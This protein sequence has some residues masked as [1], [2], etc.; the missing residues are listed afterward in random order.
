MGINNKKHN[1]TRRLVSLFV[2][3]LRCAVLNFVEGNSA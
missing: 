1:I 2:I 3:V